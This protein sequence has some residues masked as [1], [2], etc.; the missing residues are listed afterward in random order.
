MYYICLKT[1]KISGSQ[2][3]I[4]L[5]FLIG[6][7][8]SQNPIPDLSQNTNI[9]S[10]KSP[11]NQVYI[12]SIDGLNIYDGR[13]VRTFRPSTH[14]MYGNNIQ[15]NFYE[16]SLNQIWFCTYE[17]IHCYNPKTDQLEY[18]FG[19]SD[20]DTDIYNDYRIIE[21]DGYSLWFIAGEYIF[22][23]DIYNHKI[24]RKWKS[25]VQAVK[26][27]KR[28][29]S[30]INSLFIAVSDRGL[31]TF[32]IE[33]STGVIID[34]T[35]YSIPLQAMWIED[36][37]RMY[38]GTMDGRLIHFNYI[39][40]EII[41]EH[42]VN[43]ISV[44][45]INAF[46]RSHIIVSSFDKS[47]L[48]DT[49]NDS[50]LSEIEYKNQVTGKLLDR[51]L[52]VYVSKDS[53]QWISDDGNGV[54]YLN[55]QKRKFE[56][57]LNEGNEQHS[58]IGIFPIPNKSSFLVTT[59]NEGIYILSQ[60]GDVI[61]SNNQISSG[62]DLG[63]ILSGM[64]VDSIHF[65]FHYQQYFYFYN[66]LH[67]DFERLNYAGDNYLEYGVD[68]Q[69]LPDEGVV[70]C[71]NSHYLFKLELDTANKIY[72]D[73]LYT[74][75]DTTKIIVSLENVADSIYF[76]SLNEE[77][78]LVLKYDRND[79][80]FKLLSSLDIQG[81]VKS[82]EFA[83]TSN[84][85]FLS[86]NNGLFKINLD[87]LD[88][89]KIDG[90]NRVF[91]QCIYGIEKVND[92]EFWL[93]TNMGL[94]YWNSFSDSLHQ[95]QEGDGIQGLEYNTEAHF[96]ADDGRLFFGGINGLNV[97]YP[98]D[99]KLLDHEAP[100]LISDYMIDDS[101]STEFGAANFI[102]EIELPYHKN[103]IS[104]KFHAVDYAGLTSTR[105]KFKMS[106]IDGKFVESSTEQGFSRYPNLPAGS[107]T[108]NIIGSNADQVWNKSIRQIKVIIHPPYWQTWWFRS[109]VVAGILGIIFL[110][111][112]N[113]YR[114]KM[115]EK[116]FLLKEQALIISKQ[117]AVEIERNRIAN[118][119]HDDLGGGLTTIS[120]LSQRIQ[121]KLVDLKS[122]KQLEKINNQAKALVNNM[123]EI[124]WAM[125][126]RFDKV[127]NLL[128]FIRRY[129][130]ES[131]DT[132]Q[133]ELSFI[134]EIGN[135]QVPISGEYRRNIFLACKEII[136]NIIKHAKAKK[137]GILISIRNHHLIIEIEDD[138]IGF[139]PSDEISGNGLENILKRIQKCKGKMECSSVKGVKYLIEIPL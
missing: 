45:N 53:T 133:I 111:L 108:F 10:L 47:F 56:T 91:N 77:K 49:N 31:Q 29:K 83:N 125:N 58:V 113:F 118:E 94:Y 42:V 12:S 114:R 35:N 16:D 87:A 25:Y 60:D 109:I 39:T 54:Y 63:T 38:A 61:K 139:N 18:F 71:D 120:Y 7:V 92:H 32:S 101:S 65:L 44:A 135:S 132:Y 23:F 34:S 129:A 26:D 21:L 72:L 85:V 74:L 106:G 78:V 115:R 110:I 98:D 6:K 97:F 15:S 43:N 73:T 105:V 82:V 27:I 19:K 28:A 136:H 123:S 107:Y 30:D 128:A 79:K 104:F 9:Y 127:D 86:N 52:N 41:T 131:L 126:S 93:S 57:W 137:V 116:D 36:E 40:N 90:P 122:E 89:E 103:T 11:L 51:V 119:M 76:A 75:P 80:I 48:W 46:D 112:R 59:R 14:N 100:V 70:F 84:E 96:L 102:E 22:E 3:F 62:L 37:T 95:F 124:I 8:F 88:F 99:I 138:G 69:A 50:L 17:A 134:H 55:D 130:K 67:N 121:G 66:V 33:N 81:G 1:I 2:R 20:L 5:F 68:L 64:F 117:K 13:N 24:V 4:F